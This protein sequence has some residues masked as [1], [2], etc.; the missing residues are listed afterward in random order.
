[1]DILSR[2]RSLPGS[3]LS[4]LKF[5]YC[6]CLIL[7]GAIS[8]AKSYVSSWLTDFTKEKPQLQDNITIEE[9]VDGIDDNGDKQSYNDKDDTNQT[10]VARTETFNN[11]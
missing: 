4:S 5:E 2:A 11:T 6:F 10:V 1:M 8:S 3:W 7:G 9:K